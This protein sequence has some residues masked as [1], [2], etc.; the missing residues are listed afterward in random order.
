[1]QQILDRV[2]GLDVHRDSVVA[3]FRRLG[4]KGGVVRENERFTTR[5]AIGGLGAVRERTWERS[6]QRLAEGY[7]TTLAAAGRDTGVRRAA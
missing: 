2:A 1:M 5:L 7:H 4:P 3:C 6:R